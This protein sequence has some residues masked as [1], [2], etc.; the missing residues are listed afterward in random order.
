MKKIALLI[1]CITLFLTSCTSDEP[2]ET[3]IF[4]MDT[5]IQLRIWGE[6]EPLTAVA[7]L[8]R[9][10]D[11]SFNVHSEGSEI[12]A[13]NRDKNANLS[14]FAVELL[15]A[16]VSYSRTTDGA[17][18]PTVFPVVE[19]WKEAADAVPVPELK[20]VGFENIVITGQ[21]AKLENGAS[22]D[23]GGI[24]KGFAAQKSIELLQQAGVETA[25]LSLGGN[26]QT[27]GAKPDGSKWAVGIADPDAPSEHA[28]VVEF[29]GSMALVTSGGYQRYYEIG[30]ERYHHIID[31][32]TGFPAEN[33]LASVT[34]LAKNGTMADA[35][36][37]ALF[38]MGL[39]QAV[40]FWRHQTDF[41]AVFILKDGS[42]LATEG[43]APMLAQCE[44]TVIER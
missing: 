22:L 18:D 24:A 9:E 19:Q 4:A 10:L 1:L 25:L 31:P 27:L 40:D 32:K 43:A 16:A 44:F 2:M 29:E 37:T 6:A 5:F 28:A 41:E 11:R 15:N 21:V 26:V 34:I 38:V 36:S 14:P 35:Y 13:L 23:L 20:S 17:F 42:L 12:F 7:D 3:E 8:I 30:A 39:E 33:E